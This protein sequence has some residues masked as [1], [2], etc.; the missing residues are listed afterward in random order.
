MPTTPNLAM[1]LLYSAQAQK[2]ITHNEAL[3]LLDA[4][5][6]GCI[7]AVA[8]DPVP[9]DASPGDMWIVGA[10]PAGAWTGRAGQIAVFTDG[11]WRFI[12]PKHGMRLYNRTQGVVMIFDEGDWQAPTAVAAPAGGAVVDLE[13]RAALGEILTVLRR[14]G[15][16][17]A[18]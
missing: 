5:V 14:S 7:R 11:G 2:E 15:L 12:Q 4:M 1:P 16:L 3:V 18:T 10:G 13:G 17:G 9:F 8:S 6:P